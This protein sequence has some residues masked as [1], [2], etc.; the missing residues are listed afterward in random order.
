MFVTYYLFSK[1]IGGYKM[2][3]I[4]ILIT[5]VLLNLFVIPNASAFRCSD[6]KNL[7]TYGMLAGSQP[8]IIWYKIEPQKCICEVESSS[9]SRDGKYFEHNK[10]FRQTGT[11]YCN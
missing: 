4:L 7:C 9:L 5:T 10:R 3:Y 8:K 11:T 1:A 6:C 2:K